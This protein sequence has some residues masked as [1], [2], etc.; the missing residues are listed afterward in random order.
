MNLGTLSVLDTVPNLM[1]AGG[2]TVTGMAC[3]Y[4]TVKR[5]LRLA[6]DRRADV[7][8]AMDDAEWKQPERDRFADALRRAGAATLLE[9]G[10][11]HG[12]SG[13]F[14]ADDGFAVTCIDLS[15]ELVGRCRAKGLDAEVMDFGAMTFPAASFDAAFAMNRLLHVPRAELDMVLRSIHDV[16]VPSGL[17]YWGQYGGHE[18]EGVYADD[19]YEP[20][21]FFSRLTDEQIQRYAQ[22]AF[23]IVDFHTI[24]FDRPGW[25]YQALILRLP[26]H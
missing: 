12:V 7:H 17:F 1:I 13:R 18:Y 24:T 25:S 10:A 26:R 9:V 16:I 4:Q 8:D 3:E 14:F 21:R 22:R 5:D 23:E 6:Y 19:D 20:K 11:G 15:P 2:T